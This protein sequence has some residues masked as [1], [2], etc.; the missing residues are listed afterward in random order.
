MTRSLHWL[1]VAALA[2]QFTVGYSLDV[3]GRGR[4]GAA[5]AAGN[6]VGDAGGE[7]ISTSSATMDCSP[8][9]WSSG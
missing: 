1:T 2:A 7:A 9:T 3:G 4:A 5:G 8:P 6:P